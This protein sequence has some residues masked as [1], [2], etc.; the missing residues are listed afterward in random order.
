MADEKEPAERLLDVLNSISD[1]DLT[2]QQQRPYVIARLMAA[3]WTGAGVIE[4][5]DHLLFPDVL[6][7][8]KSDGSWEETKVMLRVP[9]E[10]DQRKSRVQA[11]ELAAKEKIDEQ[12]DRDLFA[13][14]ENLCLLALSIRNRSEPHEPWEPDPLIL[15]GRYDKVCLQRMWNKID[16]LASILDPAPD[17]ISKGEIIALIAAI[18]RSRNLGPLVVYGSAAQA[19]FVVSMVDILMSLLGSKLS[20]ESIEHLIQGTSAS[21]DSSS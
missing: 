16:H 4:F 1:S 10:R 9:R 15:E 19:S 8:R 6:V 18:H 13:T 7:R 21:N 3:D 2:P 14:L 5:A 12:K 17:Q 11:R 20:S